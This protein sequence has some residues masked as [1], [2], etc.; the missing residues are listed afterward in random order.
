MTSIGGSTGEYLLTIQ[1]PA[2]TET[3][4]KEDPFAEKISKVEFAVS[5]GGSTVSRNLYLRQAHFL[6]VADVAVNYLPDGS[7]YSFTVRSNSEWVVKPG[8]LSDPANILD[9][10]CKP[11]FL[12][13]SGGYDID[14]ITFSFQLV[15]T[16]LISGG[17]QITFTLGD[18]TGRAADVPV[19][20]NGYN[21]GVN[22]TAVPRRIG[23]NDYLTH[24]YIGK[25]WMV[26]NSMEGTPLHAYGPSPDKV[27]GYYYTWANRNTACPDGWRIPTVAEV[28]THIYQVNTLMYEAT[29]NEHLAGRWWWGEWMDPEQIFAGWWRQNELK[30]S[31][32]GSFGFWWY[33]GTSYP[34]N[35]FLEGYKEGLL[36]TSLS[37]AEQNVSTSVRCVHD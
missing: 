13:Q 21:C 18:P 6:T 28:G 2:F 8:S 23:G 25:C 5:S 3:E 37:I 7:V 4:I 33:E 19:T 31:N 15:N 10:A 26:Q 22:G 24:L 9:P 1:P 36:I 30:G 35:E 27:N 34:G 14:G 11:A 29:N 32:W 17:G 12:A 16:T 20:I